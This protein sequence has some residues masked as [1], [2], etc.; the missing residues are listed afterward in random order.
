[1]LL[2]SVVAIGLHIGSH[3]VGSNQFNNVNP[4]I[5]VRTEDDVVIGGYRNS[6]RRNTFY[7]AKV[8]ETD[9]HP[10]GV[11]VGAATGYLL[12]VTPL[13][14]GTI[15]MG[16]FRFLVIPPVAKVTPLTFHLSMEF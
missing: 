5:Y 13:V 15:R 9:Q 3:H 10:F 8:F 7:V 2:E 1:M 12:P 6:I 16:Q 4:G 11:V 14:A